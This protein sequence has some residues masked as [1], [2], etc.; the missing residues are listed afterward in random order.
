MTRLDFF[1][2]HQEYQIQMTELTVDNLLEQF[3]LAKLTGL[4][5]P[6]KNLLRMDVLL[7]V[8]N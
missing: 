4:E 5:R 8:L 7:V 1:Q 3:T 2:V 6:G